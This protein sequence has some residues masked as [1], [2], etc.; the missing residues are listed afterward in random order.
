MTLRGR[1]ATDCKFQVPD[2]QETSREKLQSGFNLSKKAPLVNPPDSHN[3]VVEQS[4]VVPK[5]KIT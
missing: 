4:E 3:V 1:R 2:H 5:E